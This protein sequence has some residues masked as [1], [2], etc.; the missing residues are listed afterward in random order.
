MP[1]TGEYNVRVR[2]TEGNIRLRSLLLR[3][4]SCPSGARI[5]SGSNSIVI[6][7]VRLALIF[8]FSL[9]EH[10]ASNDPNW[11][12]R[13]D[14]EYIEEVAYTEEGQARGHIRP[15]TYDV[16]VSGLE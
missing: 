8:E 4:I 9:G 2:D 3:L 11:N 15:G 1:S 16:Y 6:W 10:V 12:D 7:N 13:Q 14:G 5:V